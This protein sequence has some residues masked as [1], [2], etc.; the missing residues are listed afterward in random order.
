M[1]LGLK[2]L[3]Q[4]GNFLSLS[5]GQ[6]PPGV[7]QPSPHRVSEDLQVWSSPCRHYLFISARAAAAINKRCLE[8][9]TAGAA[10]SRAGGQE[11][12]TIDFPS[13]KAESG[14]RARGLQPTSSARVWPEGLSPTRQEDS[15]HQDHPAG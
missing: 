11:E 1:A 4:A 3:A 12:S 15:V 8:Q 13:H 14:V 7:T 9:A 2:T 5:P 6:K 10:L